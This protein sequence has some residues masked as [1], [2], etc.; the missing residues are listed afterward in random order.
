MSL[1]IN[2]E[3]SVNE[4]LNN[5]MI[6]DDIDFVPDINTSSFTFGLT[7]KRFQ[8]VCLYIDMRGST[9]ILEKHNSSTVIKIHKAFFI[10][11]LKIVRSFNG[12]VRSFNGDSILAFFES[13]TTESIEN[14][15]KSALTLKYMLLVDDN[16]LKN[17]VENMYGTT[18]DIGIGLDLGSTVSSKVGSNGYNNQDLIWIGKNVNKSVKIS[19]VRNTPYNIGISKRLYDKLPNSVLY[20][21]DGY[22]IWISENMKYNNNYELILKTSYYRTV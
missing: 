21:K 15:L 5:N 3:N 16:C 8:S 11:I 19:D 1:K 22:N 13:H 14:A 9:A 18:I 17:K 20:D 4:T 10:T 2:I 12:E 7:G 6:V